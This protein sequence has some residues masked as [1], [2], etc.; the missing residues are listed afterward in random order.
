MTC[1]RPPETSVSLETRSITQA[2]ALKSRVDK[3]AQ[4]SRHPPSTEL[5]VSVLFACHR[6]YYIN[7]TLT[8]GSKKFF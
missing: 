4:A 7:L 8:M 2:T 3:T 5:G 6:L 1:P